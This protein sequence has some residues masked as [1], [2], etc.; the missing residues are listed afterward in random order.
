[1][2]SVL[3]L[4]TDESF[5]GL[6]ASSPGL[7]C[8]AL[9]R[10]QVDETITEGGLELLL[11]AGADAIADIVVLGDGLPMSVSLTIAESIHRSG[12]SVAAI[13]VGEPDT[14]M[15]LLAMRAGV[16]DIIPSTVTE[17]ELKV[18][19]HRVV[20][21]RSVN[22]LTHDSAPV[23]EEAVAET[24]RTIV[25][26]GPKGGIGR[27]TVAANL[28]VALARTSPMDTVLVDLDLAFGDISTVLNLTPTH[29]IAD[30]FESTAALDTLILKTFLTV[31]RSDLYVLCGASSPTTVDKVNGPQ[32]KQLLRQLSS[33]FK[34]VVVDTAAGMDEIS[35]SAI[36]EASDLI[37]VSSADASSTKALRKEMAALSSLDEVTSSRHVVL[38]FAERRSGAKVRAAEAAIGQ[39]V[40]VVVPRCNELQELTNIGRALMEGTQRSAA[41]R[42]IRRLVDLIHEGD[43]SD[44]TSKHRGVL[45]S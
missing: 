31:H 37:L 34:Y 23:V 14:E 6:V 13:L 43:D 32:I 22:A 15:V 42:G 29:N 30:A 1:M 9:D 17:D 36:E 21:T 7:S 45:A 33:Q 20:E 4:A 39:P 26:S 28:A 27:S 35:M 8:V 2:T 12:Q 10:G 24:N 19:F 40:H 38:N 5:S 16:R 25:V 44:L 3:L 11:G 41:A 18:L